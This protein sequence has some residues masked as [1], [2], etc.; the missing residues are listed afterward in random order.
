V[1]LQ[2]A[3]AVML[4]ALLIWTVVATVLWAVDDGGPVRIQT[5]DPPAP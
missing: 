1:K 5:T 4:G 2:I 3:I